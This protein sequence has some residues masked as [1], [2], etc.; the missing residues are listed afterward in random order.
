MPSLDFVVRGQVMDAETVRNV[1]DK[2][3]PKQ[4]KQVEPKHGGFAVIGWPPGYID[5]AKEKHEARYA[6]WYAMS[7]QLKRKW[8]DEAPKARDEHAWRAEH[9]PHKLATRATP[10][11]ADALAALAKKSGWTEVVVLEVIRGKRW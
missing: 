9:K 1:S 10:D 2:A 4:P 8:A 6:S 11:G 5:A 3:R 7:E